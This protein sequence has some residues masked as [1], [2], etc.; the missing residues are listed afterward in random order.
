M[1]GERKA[2]PE[3]TRQKRLAHYKETLKKLAFEAGANGIEITYTVDVARLEDVTCITYG[4]LDP[5]QLDHPD[6]S[7]VRDNKVCTCECHTCKRRWFGEGQPII[8]DGKIV[9][10]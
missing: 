6:C 3:E 7:V 9:R 8:R 10:R 4:R 5:G 1:I 2:T